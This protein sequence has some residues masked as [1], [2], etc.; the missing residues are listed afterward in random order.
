MHKDRMKGLQKEHRS[1]PE[2]HFDLPGPFKESINQNRFA[3]HSLDARTSFSE[4]HPILSKS[5]VSEHDKGF[6]NGVNDM[7]ARDGTKV[8][9][10]RTDNARENIPKA[11]HEFCTES[12]ISIESSLPYAPESNGMA[13]RLVQENWTRARVMMLATSLPAEIW[14]EAL[15]HANWRRNRLPSARI[16]QSIPTQQWDENPVF[17]SGQYRN[18]EQQN[19]HSSITQ[20]M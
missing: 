10:I 9:M 18:L 16:N 20:L 1:S 15:A 8:R 19:M 11:L 3:L 4:V 17:N 7:F 5:H 13:E 14:D 12:G 2:I 6:I